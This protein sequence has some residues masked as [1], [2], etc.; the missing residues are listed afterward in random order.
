MELN[1]YNVNACLD[2]TLFVDKHTYIGED[3]DPINGFNPPHFYACP[4]YTCLTYYL[5]QFKL[6]K[7]FTLK[8]GR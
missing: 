4:L 2:L 7:M 1:V 3:W 8:N 6:K 5:D